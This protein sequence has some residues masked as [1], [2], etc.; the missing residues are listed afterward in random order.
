MNKRISFKIDC[1]FDVYFWHLIPSI[2]LNF[3]SQEIEFEWLCLGV[4][5]SKIK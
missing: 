2:N 1:D 3:H 4:Y 5:I